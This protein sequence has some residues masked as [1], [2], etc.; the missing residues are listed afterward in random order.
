MLE[1]LSEL[2]QLT[3]RV[4]RF[5]DRIVHHFSQQYHNP[6]DHFNE[7]DIDETCAMLAGLMYLSDM[8]NVQNVDELSEEY[9][10]KLLSE[11]DE[12]GQRKVFD[13]RT[14]IADEYLV[15]IGK[16]YGKYEYK[17]YMKM[18]SEIKKS[19]NVL[20]NSS[21]IERDSKKLYSTYIQIFNKLKVKFQKSSSIEQRI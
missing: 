3:E 7:Q 14:L 15:K 1:I 20:M 8:K 11:L 13:N 18:M 10:Y 19:K 5:L 12:I 6:L 4:D 2:S 9:L 21:A 17:R 16:Q